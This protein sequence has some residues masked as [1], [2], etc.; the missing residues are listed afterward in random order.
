M[1]RVCGSVHFIFIVLGC[2]GLS[3]Q[4]PTLPANSA[5]E[6]QLRTVEGTVVNSVTGEPIRRALVSLSAISQHFAFTDS[7][8]R[9]SFENVPAVRVMLQATRPGYFAPHDRPTFVD[10]AKA[11]DALKLELIPSAVISGRVLGADDQP[12][13]RA[14]VEIF[15]SLINE[16]RR[17]WTSHSASPA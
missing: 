3:G 16:G 17:R 7:D 5:R 12:L 9:F 15:E 13:E 2:L 1:L 14:P 8:G 4:S 11:S 10:L 6:P